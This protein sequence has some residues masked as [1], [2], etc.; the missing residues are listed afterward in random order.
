[1]ENDNKE[2]SLCLAIII[3]F[4]IQVVLAIIAVAFDVNYS[5]YVADI[6]IYAFI[7][8]SALILSCHEIMFFLCICLFVKYPQNRLGRA[9]LIV[10]ALIYVAIFIIVVIECINAAIWCYQCCDDCGCVDYLHNALI[11]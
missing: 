7:I 8:L 6:V 5:T 9:M 3:L 2:R 10:I 1:M 4:A 11:N